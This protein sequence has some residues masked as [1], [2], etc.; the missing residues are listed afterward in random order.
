MGTKPDDGTAL[1]FRFQTL[2]TTR[3]APLTVAARPVFPLDSLPAT[4]G[5]LLTD[6]ERRLGRRPDL[7]LYDAAAYSAVLL[8]TLSERSLSFIVRTPHSARIDRLCT[9]HAGLLCFH[10]PDYEIRTTGARISDPPARFT[11]VAV[12][13]DLLDRARIDLPHSEH[14][15]KWFLYATNLAPIPGESETDFALRV[16]LLYKERWD[17]ETG[18]RG[19]EELRGFT[20]ALHYDVRL[21][22]FFLAAI[23]ANLW[24]L[25]RERSGE[26]WTKGEVALYLGLGLL[27]G[28]L[29][30]RGVV[31]DEVEI[32]AR[33]VHPPVPLHRSDQKP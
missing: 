32:P 20:H 25:Q 24:A 30:E 13:R 11:L 18:F 22:Q 19:I 27:L 16:A 17:I 12:S 2:L 14:E 8:R 28:L 21:L 4:L 6:A 26:A 31:G 3:G 9:E 33:A 15:V 29:D 23:L 7:L 1:A 10:V 5:V